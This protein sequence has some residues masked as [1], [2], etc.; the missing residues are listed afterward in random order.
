MDLTGVLSQPIAVDVPHS[1]APQIP[2]SIMLA[3]AKYPFDEP[4]SE[5]PDDHVA[6]TVRSADVTKRAGSSLLEGGRCRAR[7][8]ARVER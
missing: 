4:R 7:L 5:K 6:V 2:V 3:V 1:L 8:V